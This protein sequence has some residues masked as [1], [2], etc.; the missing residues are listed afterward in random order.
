MVLLRS[1]KWG[2]WLAAAVAVAPLALSN[3]PLLADDFVAQVNRPLR[4]V[5]TDRR[6]DTVLLPL[7]ADLPEPPAVV[8]SQERAALL[9]WHGPQWNACE[10][11]ASQDPCRKVLDALPG[12]VAERNFRVAKV[13]AQP[14]GV[15]GIDLDLVSRNLYTELGEPP[16]LAAARHGYMDALEN[17]AVLVHVE[18]SRLAKAGRPDDAVEL[19]V[20]WV[21]F[22]RQFAD[23]PFLAETLWAVES[24]FLGLTRIRDVLY[25]DH[26]QDP[27]KATWTRLREQIERLDPSALISID[28]MR[29]PEADLVGRRQLLNR[30][31]RR[32][33]GVDTAAFGS[34]MARLSSLDRPLRLF[35][36]AAYWESVGAGHADFLETDRTL[37]AFWQDWVKRWDLPTFDPV[38][39]TK[40]EFVLK[41][42][43]SRRFA[44]LDLNMDG[45]EDL[46]R[47]RQRLRAEL[48]GTR[49]AMG[50]YAYILSQRNVPPALNALRPSILTAID[51]DP[52]SQRRQDL[53]YLIVGRDTPRDSEGKPAPYTV[54]LF[55][56]DPYPSFE[57]PLQ[58]GTF[59][60]Y[61]VGPDNLR[62]SARNATQGRPG[63][64]GDYLLW[65]P[66]ISLY[67][68][69]LIDL[70]TL[71]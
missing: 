62:Q 9:G 26:Q 35:S 38:M 18:T 40:S 41:V 1:G 24:M 6:S 10:A 4:E 71:N 43:P 58:P 12:L 49:M 29:L 65:P 28:R 48:A 32:G 59:V 51:T 39:Q 57:I 20:N 33:S 46:F 44:V 45:F 13:F 8:R 2:R 15:E 56:P 14:Y 17:M 52:Y 50:A 21:L 22:A 61:A 3:S 27:R 42:K 69:R 70:G 55:P 11:W 23:R 64:P 7:L 19:L 60:L 5:P 47:E 16:M 34:T 67:R 68:Q 30:V 66:A 36:S 37:T 31:M 53:Q 63:V 25:D 54:R